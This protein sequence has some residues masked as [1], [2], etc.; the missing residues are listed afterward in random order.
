VLALVLSLAVALMPNGT[1]RQEAPSR[2]AA[3]LPQKGVLIIGKSLA[4]VKLGYTQA[5]VKSLWGGNYKPCPKGFCT[6]PTWLYIYPRGE[7]LGA[8]VRFRNNKVI[9]VF[10]LG[11]VAG[12]R[13]EQGVT[14]ADPASRVYD[15]YGRPKYTKCIGFE[16]LSISGRTV[17][18]SFYLTSGVVYGFALTVP[19]LNPCQ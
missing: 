1:A 7:P 8:A 12:W 9:A 13:T 15:L 19:G 2:Q 3:S 14:I 18:T 11:A 6:D 4:G 10:T 17:V 5:K 16:A